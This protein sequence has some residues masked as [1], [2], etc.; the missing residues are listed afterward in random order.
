MDFEVRSPFTNTAFDLESDEASVFNLNFCGS[1][2]GKMPHSKIFFETR[3]E[4]DFWGVTVT[5]TLRSLVAKTYW[6]K[7]IMYLLVCTFFVKSSFGLLNCTYLVTYS[8]GFTWSIG[9]GA[10]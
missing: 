5:S 7:K 6:I 9:R 10:Y 3:E 2:N 8:Y 4:F 1:S